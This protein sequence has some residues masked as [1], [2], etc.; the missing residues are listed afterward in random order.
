[1]LLYD[2]IVLKHNF[3]VFPSCSEGMS[4][5]VATCM[6]YGIIPIITKECGFASASCMIILD[7]FHI[8]CVRDA[9]QK[10][11]LMSNDEILKCV[12]IV[13]NMQENNSL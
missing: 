1:M 3:I 13:S 7:D 4:T 8:T 10:T 6:A 2:S 9:I 12:K 5:A 11:L